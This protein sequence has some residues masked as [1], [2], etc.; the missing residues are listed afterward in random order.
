MQQGGKAPVA[1]GAGGAGTVYW[2]TG[3]AGAGKTTVGGR[4]CERLRASGRPAVLLDG[5]RLRTVFDAEQA[6]AAEDRL[7]LAKTYGRLCRELAEQGIDV[8][9]AT[10]SMFHAVRAWNRAEI[11][12]YREIYLRVPRDVLRARDPKGIYARHES[13]R[14]PHVVGH[15]LRPELP[16]DPDLVI[17]ND[18]PIT[19]DAAVELIWNTLV[20]AHATEDA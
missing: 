20:V 3:L 7:R 18:G 6:H 19:P 5:D 13:G 15:D 14:Q 4:L 16:L 1:A 9:C 17:D 2:I 11:A 8:V 12:R 10:I